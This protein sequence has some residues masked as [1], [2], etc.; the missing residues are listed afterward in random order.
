MSE[1]MPA[2]GDREF[3]R[4][5]FR[6]ALFTRRGLSAERAEQLADRLAQRDYDRDDRRLCLECAHLQRPGTCFAAKQ[7]WIHGADKRLTPVTDILQRCGQ[8]DFQKP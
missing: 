5:F 4:F 2:W 3:T 7:G 1:R 8:F 6:Q